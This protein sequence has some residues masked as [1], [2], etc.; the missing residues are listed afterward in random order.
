TSDYDNPEWFI[1]SRHIE[2]FP[3]DK[4]VARRSTMFVG[5]IPVMYMPKYTQ[6]LREN[7]PHL[8]VIPGYEKD[9][10]MYLLTT[11]R[12]YPTDRL[13]VHYHLDY[14]ERKDLGWGIDVEY[15]PGKLGGGIVRT[16]YMKE[17]T[18]SS[19]RIWGERMLPT[20]ERE[21][22]RLEWRHKWN[23]DPQT[24]AIVQYAKISDADFLKKYWDQEYWQDENPE[25]YALVTRALPMGSLSILTK[26]RVNR[27]E[28]STVERLPEISYMLNNQEIGATG[29]YF[30]SSNVFSQ[31][32]KKNASPSDVSNRTSRFDTDNEISRPFKVSF[33]EM[34]PYVGTAQT[35]YSRTLNAEDE[36]TVRGL[37]KTGM[38]V[39][40]KFYRV[41][42]VSFDKW[43][44]EIDRLR[45]VITPTAGYSYQHAP[46]FEASKLYP[47]DAIDA[48]ARSHGVDIGIE[49]K[50]QTKR[51]GKVVDLF[52]SLVSTTY[53]LSDMESGAWSD[54]TFDNEFR[55]NEFVAFGLDGVYDEEH[56]RIKTFNIDLYLAGKDRWSF[57]ISRR[58]TRDDD[59]IV[60]AHLAYVINSKW[61][62]DVY[63]RWNVDSGEWKDQQYALVRDLHSWEVELAFRDKRGYDDA[64][65]EVWIIFRLKAFP[66]FKMDGGSSFHQRKAGAQNS[67]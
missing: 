32:V 14:F 50:I 58:Y 20:P 34:R 22:Y 44:I 36:N 49:N 21:R 28:F 24:S 45:H 54:I 60:T 47:F 38:D 35:Y 23:V 6:D 29:F 30:K 2:V 16:Y 33:L 46:T 37:F 42:D 53:N 5:G 56:K 8:K 61:R 19:D 62:A 15:A 4:A 64:G 26:V 40:T 1:R 66:S 10:G 63:E 48:R 59:D 55:P 3:G 65:N 41:F 13:G 17:R 39:S 27:F 9:K 11:Y 52:R 43:G 18:I 31:L 67:N 7:R 57:D 12:T 51:K 25:T